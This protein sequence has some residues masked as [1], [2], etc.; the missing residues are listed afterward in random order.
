MDLLSI[1]LQL[2]GIFFIIVAAI[3]IHEAGHLFFGLKTG[4]RFISY[5]LLSFTWM[6]Q[7]DKVVFARNKNSLVLGQCLMTPP[8]KEEDFHFILYNYGGGLANLFFALTTLPILLF[9]IEGPETFWILLFVNFWINLFF[10]L[11][12]L[13]PFRKNIPN[14]GANVKEAKKSAD[15]KHGLFVMLTIAKHFA[16][17]KI[18]SD[19]EEEF[20]TVT[21]EADKN[22][23]FVAYLIAAKAEWLF[24][25]KRNEEGF[26]LLSSLK[27]E[28]L[29]ALPNY[30]Q[31]SIY[32]DYLYYYSAIAPDKEKA[33]R[34]Y[35]NPKLQKLLKMED[36][37]FLL[38]K[39]TYIIYIGKD[40]V[41]GRKLIEKIKRNLPLYPYRGVAS[42][43]EREMLILQEYIN[44]KMT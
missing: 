20:F 43:K 7:K 16:D 27:E 28:H 31:Q 44:E 40:F 26:T 32:A 8:E 15:A 39:A 5:S 21:P 22:N 24:D 6:K 4:Y 3:A 13:L 29:Q 30:Y 33:K 37:S 17:G 38:V 11:I 9:T 18:L 14:D 42:E 10:S 41:E 2:I 35:A 34:Y 36:L 12:N 25:K 1:V 19:F 23:Y